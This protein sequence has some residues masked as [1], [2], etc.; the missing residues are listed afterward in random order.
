MIRQAR[1]EILLHLFFADDLVTDD[2]Y[3]MLEQE[4]AR[5]EEEAVKKDAKQKQKEFSRKGAHRNSVSNRGDCS[6]TQIFGGSLEM[7]DIQ[8]TSHS[9]HAIE[10]PPPPSL[11][12]AFVRDY[13]GEELLPRCVRKKV[14]YAHVTEMQMTLLQRL[15][16]WEKHRKDHQMEHDLACVLEGGPS[17]YELKNPR[18][19][20][21]EVQRL[22]ELYA[23][24]YAAWLRGD[25][26]SLMYSQMRRL[27]KAF[28]V[29]RRAANHIGEVVQ[30]R[31][32]I[33]ESVALEDNNKA[34]SSMTAAQFRH[35]HEGVIIKK[36][37]TTNK[38]LTAA[39][40]GFF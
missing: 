13:R 7:D 11:I 18:P 16:K 15:E 33:E 3:E 29:W 1:T 21:I 5:L 23:Q 19:R 32:S 36:A 25:Y 6:I 22:R 38:S 24:T 37:I 10:A 40:A 30:R 28:G 31:N 20:V 12:E 14:L 2:D 4:D 17:S 26:K 39:M 8:I 9:K 27:K 34:M 35:R